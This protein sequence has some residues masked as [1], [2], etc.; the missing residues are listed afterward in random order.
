MKTSESTAL[1]IK[2][3]PTQCTIT[4]SLALMFAPALVQNFTITFNPLLTH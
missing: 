2:A 4:E 1:S 3:D